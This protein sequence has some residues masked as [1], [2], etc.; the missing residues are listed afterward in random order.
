[1]R[2]CMVLYDV[3]EFGGLEE[4]LVTLAIGLRGQGHESSVLSTAWV[5]RNN[6]YVRRLAEGDVPF[7][8]VPRWLSRL[9]SDWDTK[10]TLLNALVWL[11]SPLV[12]PMAA[13][14]AVI[15][16]TRWTPSLESARGWLRR[17]L[18]ERFLAKDRRDTLGRL[19]LTWWRWRWRPDLLHIQGYTT[20]LLFAVD[21][22][23][24]GGLPVVYEEHQTPDPQ[25]DWWQGFSGTINKAAAVVAVSQRS[26]LGL[27]SVCGV[28][29]PIFVRPPL[30]PD[31]AASGPAP[32]R[33]GTAPVL[34]TCVARL[35]VTKGL[36]YL[37]DAMARVTATHPG[38]ELRIYGDGPLRAELQQHARQLALDADAIFPGAFTSRTD[39]ARIL[40]HADIFVMSSVLEG[41]PLGLV[42]AMAF[43]CPIVATSV[44]GIPELIEHG[45]NGLLCPPADPTS[46]ARNLVTLVDAPELRAR[47]GEAARRSYEKGGFQPAAVCQRLA[48]V[49]SHA[50]GSAV[51][52]VR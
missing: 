27:Q 4:Y 52:P 17:Q 28:T 51:A 9:A 30:L 11:A 7:V 29:R 31:P 41:Q 32:R 25:F 10:V 43:G 46:L 50:L 20:N 40:S 19:L 36:T 18:L 45:V 49:Y 39:L 14:R 38:V 6:Q 37:L 23:H 3:Q 16:R 33:Q 26:A 15:R 1:M 42:E 47:L 44:G 21:W 48:Q 12:Y 2:V 13:V 24:A 35:Y 5:D 34:I 8:Q 22:A